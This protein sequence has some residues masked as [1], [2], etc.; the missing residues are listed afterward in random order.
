VKFADALARYEKA[1]ENLRRVI[2]ATEKPY[3]NVGIALLRLVG[4]IAGAMGDGPRSVRAFV[5]AAERDPDDDD[6]V[7]EAEAAV[8]LNPEPALVGGSRPSVAPP[9][10]GWG[11]APIRSRSRGRACWWPAARSPSAPAAPR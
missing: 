4:A 1:D 3:S 10:Q 8:T 9:A 2:E 11:R 5:Q 6:L 7:A